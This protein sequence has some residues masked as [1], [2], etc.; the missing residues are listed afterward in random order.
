MDCTIGL[1]GLHLTWGYDGDILFHFY[2]LEEHMNIPPG[3]IA[4]AGFKVTIFFYRS[5]DELE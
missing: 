1:P 2:I 3:I 5:I 4:E